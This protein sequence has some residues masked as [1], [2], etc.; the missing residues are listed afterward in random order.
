MPLSSSLLFKKHLKEFT[1]LGPH[2]PS[3]KS[4]LI[5]IMKYYVQIWPDLRHRDSPGQLQSPAR[6]QPLTFLKDDGN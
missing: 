6:L 3:F 2:G 5:Q 4:K 1:N